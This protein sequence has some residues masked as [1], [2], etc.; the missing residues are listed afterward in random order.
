MLSRNFAHAFVLRQCI[1]RR[2]EE[3]GLIRADTQFPDQRLLRVAYLY[4]KYR[5]PKG[6]GDNCEEENSN[7]D[8][9]QTIDAESQASPGSGRSGMGG[10][11]P[12]T[13][14]RWNA[15]KEKAAALSPRLFSAADT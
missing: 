10:Y 3:S 1:S 4:F 15:G 9:G 12:A 2:C 7:E 14:Q 13:W 8:C 5:E 11:D 6:K